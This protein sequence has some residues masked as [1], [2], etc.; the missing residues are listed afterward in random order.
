MNESGY[1]VTLKFHFRLVLL[2]KNLFSFC[3]TEK[4]CIVISN[5]KIYWLINWDLQSLLILDWLVMS[6][7]VKSG[8]LAVELPR[9]VSNLF[10]EINMLP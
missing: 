9:S 7:P 5:R 3:M 8:S 4:L 6:I 10:I 2:N 1:V